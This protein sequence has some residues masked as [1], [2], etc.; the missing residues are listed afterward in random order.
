[1]LSQ[2]IYSLFARVIYRNT[3]MISK[4]SQALGLHDFD[5]HA[6]PTMLIHL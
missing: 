3:L 5:T 1:M 6:N 4:V 2:R